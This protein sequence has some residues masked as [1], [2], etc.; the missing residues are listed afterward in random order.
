MLLHP[1]RGVAKM[2]LIIASMG[3]L[4]IFIPHGQG[5]NTINIYYDI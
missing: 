5:N 3:L 1:M 2:A 4:Q